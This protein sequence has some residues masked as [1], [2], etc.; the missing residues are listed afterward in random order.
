MEGG[1]LCYQPRPSQEHPK[2]VLLLSAVN[3]NTNPGIVISIHIIVIIVLS[4]TIVIVI[5]TSIFR[6]GTCLAQKLWP[7]AICL[8]K[9]PSLH[10]KSWQRLDSVD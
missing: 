4:I 9:R 1:R 6:P 3:T 7:V 10:A 2:E 5:I 8:P